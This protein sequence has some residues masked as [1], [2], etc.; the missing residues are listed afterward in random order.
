MRRRDQQRPGHRKRVSIPDGVDP[1][2]VARRAVHVDSVE[3]KDAPSPAGWPRPRA[4]ASICDPALGRQFRQ[5]TSPRRA[6]IRSGPPPEL[7]RRRGILA[8]RR[9]PPLASV[10]GRARGR[11]AVS[12]PHHPVGRHPGHSHLAGRQ[13]F[14][15]GCNTGFAVPSLSFVSAGDVIRLAARRLDLP[16]CRVRFLSE[17]ERI[18]PKVDVA[19]SIR[20]FIGRSQ[21]RLRQRGVAGTPLDDERPAIEKLDPGDNAIAA[22]VGTLGI[23][24]F[25]TPEGIDEILESAAG[26]MGH[27]AIRELCEATT[28]DQLE[29]AARSTGR[30][31]CP[32][33][34]ERLSLMH[35]QLTSRQAAP[36]PPSSR[37]RLAPFATTRAGR[38]L[39]MMQPTSLPA[40]SKWR[41]R[42]S[43]AKRRATDFRSPHEAC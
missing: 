1:R 34:V 40:D 36:S 12:E 17:G 3:H 39:M 13:T 23:D 19:S 24:P 20:A 6:A 31:R 30:G 4:D 28:A 38:H 15:P 32:M 7:P 33:P 16:D 27:K 22:L 8:E 35:A 2:A 42:W 21:E 41:A 10:L 5:L 43:G 18:I 26:A 37:L 9:K 11:L 29:P 14:Q 25:D